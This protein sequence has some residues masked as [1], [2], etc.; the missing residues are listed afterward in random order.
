MIKMK[1]KILKTFLTM[2]LFFFTIIFFVPTLSATTI[3]VPDDYAKIQWAVDNASS[4]DT[5]FVYNGTY[6]EHIN[7]F[8]NNLT[9]IGENKDNTIIDGGWSMDAIVNVNADFINISGFT[10]KSHKETIWDSYI[11]ILLSHSNNNEIT[12]N[13]CLNNSICLKESSNNNIIANNTAL[14]DFVG[15]G[16]WS[17]NN[18][19]IANNNVS[20]H[21]DYGIILESSS[22]NNTVI[23]NFASNSWWGIGIRHYNNNNRIIGNKLSNNAY[24]IALWSSS[25]SNIVAYNNI[26]DN[27]LGICPSSDNKI[28]L[29]NFVNNWKNAESQ[30]GSASIWNSTGRIT[31][32]YNSSIYTNY[33]GNYWDDY[34]GSDADGDGIGD[35]PYVIPNENN[36]SYPLMEPWSSHR[37]VT[38]GDLNHDGEVTPTDA[39]IALQ[40][41][42]SG[43]YD[44]VADVSGDDCVTSLDALMIL[45]VAAGAISL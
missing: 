20:F 28:Y 40:L 8:K 35:T 43:E 26:S 5:I 36:D 44:S 25:N 7:I 45:Q 6:P 19:V 16:L 2:T 18:N 15:I 31:Y 22:C 37:K 29:N 12:N 24:G 32:T 1:N 23:S 13:S 33:L 4:G 38:K 41:A 14:F 21:G 9:V 27:G 34:T 39:A 42:V 11:G 10:I 17:S 30:H 3:Y